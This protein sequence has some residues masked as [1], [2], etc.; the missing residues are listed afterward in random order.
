MSIL[1]ST[2]LTEVADGIGFVE[3][4]ANVVALRADAESSGRGSSE[5]VLVDAASPFH[6]TAVHSAIRD[7]T[8]APLSAVVFTHGHVDHVGG[9]GEFEA[10]ADAGPVRVIAHEN[11][12]LRFDR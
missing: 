12:P 11:L 9:V 4:F 2:E 10:E 6:A 5:L 3:S 8:Q 1:G 7:W